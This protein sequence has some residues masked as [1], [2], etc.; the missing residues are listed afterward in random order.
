[1]TPSDWEWAPPEAVGLSSAGLDRVDSAVQ[2]LIDRR[3]LAGAATLVAKSNK[4]ARVS[5]LGR[6]GGRHGAPP[7]GDTIYRIFSMTK[8]VTALAMGILADRG[9][10]RPDDS[11]ARHLPEFQDIQVAVGREERGQVALEPPHHAPTMRELM[12]HTAGFSYGSDRNDPVDRLYRRQRLWASPNSTEFIRRLATLPLAARPGTQWRYSVS[13]DIQGAIIERMTGE[14]LSDFMAETIFE[15]LGMTDTAF[16]VSPDKK[17][18]LAQLYC[19]GTGVKLFPL[20]RNPIFPEYDR[21]PP[22]AIGGGGLTSTLW[23]YARFARLLLNRGVLPDGKRIVSESAVAAQMT[24]QIAEELIT[25]GFRAG[26]MKFR[27]GFGFGYDG[28]VVYD[29]DRAG[30]PVGTNTYFWDGVAGTWFW[31]DPEV[32]LAYVGMIQLIS[33]SSPPMQE[34]TQELIREALID[35]GR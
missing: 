6:G 12:T 1:M 15:P 21:E 25:P 11:I 26:Q 29:P 19:T 30:L 4:V 28:A 23:D 14:T 35:G 17:D 7:S 31:V 3:V 16:Y 34:M 24:N 10:W 22:M 33:R 9:L 2:D 27:P 32:D 8:P 18:R 13:A 20:W 5:L